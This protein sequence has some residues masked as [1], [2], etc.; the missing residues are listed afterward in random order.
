VRVDV[1]T[2]TLGYILVGTRPCIPD[3]IV[4]QYTTTILV[5]EWLREERL[6]EKKKKRT[7]KRK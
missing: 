6:R 2:R 5:R 3:D 7:E 4:P 1:Y